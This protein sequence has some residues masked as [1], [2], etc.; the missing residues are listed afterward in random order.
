M[1]KVLGLVGLISSCG[2]IGLYKSFR[3]KRRILLLEDFFKMVM[4]IKSCINYFREPLPD[5]F[6]KIQKK[7]GLKAHFLINETQHQ[8]VEKALE[9]SEIWP[10]KANEI[11]KN[12]PLTKDDMELIKY[13]GSFI[14]Q[15]DYDNQI[16]HFNYLEESLKKQIDLAVKDS[17]KKGPLL[18]KTGFMVG[19]IISIVLL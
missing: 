16:V 15:T 17:N 10:L 14:G 19:I 12:E 2:L 8:T 3:L 5:L 6:E 9:I 13:F 18:K 11:Y 1:F 7:D 4:E